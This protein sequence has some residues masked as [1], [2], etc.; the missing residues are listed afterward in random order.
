[1]TLLI[2]SQ[3]LCILPCLRRSLP[4]EFCLPKEKSENSLPY[5]AARTQAWSLGSATKM[6]P[7]NSLIRNDEPEEGGY[8]WDPFADKGGGRGIQFSRVPVV[9]TSVPGSASHCWQSCNRLWVPG[10]HSMLWRKAG[11]AASLLGHF[12][13]KVS[14]LDPRSLASSLLL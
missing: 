1:M 10:S 5:L 12:Y 11:S 2:A 9:V 6:H 3:L 13:S 8:P 14:A 4:Y 7:S